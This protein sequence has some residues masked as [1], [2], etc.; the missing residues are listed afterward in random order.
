MKNQMFPQ[1]F[2]WGAGTSSHQIEGN[3]NN[4][5][6]IW[7]K[8][9]GHIKTGEVSGKAA[10]S[11]ELYEKDFEL[12]EQMNLKSYRFSIEWSRIEPQR[13]NFDDNA[14]KTYRNMLESLHKRGIT[15]IVSI[16]HFTNPVWLED[17][18]NRKVIKSY[19][20][21]VDKIVASLGDLVPY[22]ITINEP[23]VFAFMGYQ[24]GVWPPGKKNIW[25]EYR[26]LKHM[27]RAH[28]NAYELINKIYVKNNWQKPAISM[29]FNLQHFV[30]TNKKITTR[31]AM[32]WARYFTNDYSIV[33]SIKYLDFIGTNHYF[34]VWMT[35]FKT[36]L[37]SPDVIQNDLGWS[38][39]PEGFYHAIIDAKKHN[40]PILITENGTADANDSKRSWFITSF[41]KEMHRAINDGANIIGYTHWSL[42]DNWEWWDGFSGKFGLAET[43]FLTFER[44]LRDSGALYGEIAKS[45]ALPDAIA[46]NP[47]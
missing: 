9:P 32:K 25:K 14:I 44:K 22:W 28:K 7:E 2:L 11:W 31:F 23:N 17:W 26:V 21:F 18:S 45:N 1:D 3:T 6:T 36:S 24:W 41:L 40:L 33:K 43:N 29:T 37:N 35:G 8:V 20:S 16:H 46:E 47:E 42:I 34:T 30:P 12:L 19:L 38:M 27:I 10:N 5:W 15:P 39:N 4:D 13:G